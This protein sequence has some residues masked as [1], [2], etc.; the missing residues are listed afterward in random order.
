MSSSANGNL[1]MSNAAKERAPRNRTLTLTDREKAAYSRGLLTLSQSVS[2]DFV[3]NRVVRQDALVALAYLPDEC[4][5]LIIVDP[6]YNKNKRFNADCFS[7]TSADEYAAWVDSWLSLLSKKMTSTSSIYICSDWQSSTAIQNA[8]SRYFKIQNRITWEREKGRGAKR[9]W[10]NCAEDIWFCTKS[11][12]FTFNIDAVKLSRRVIAP[13]RE[14]DGAPRDWDETDNGNFRLTHPSNL[15]TDISVPFWS[16]PENTDHP[17]Q[18]PEKLIAKLIL[19]SSQP[20]DIVLDPFAGS[21]TT[22][23]VAKKTNRRFIA[24]EIDELYCCL[25]QKRLDLANT[26]STI[27]GYADGVFWE[28]NT[29]AIQKQTMKRQGQEEDDQSTLFLAPSPRDRG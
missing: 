29:L 5:N 13:Y 6:P 26:D 8:A 2:L 7:K 17:T 25:A 23:V 11:D 19:A 10:K 4:A 14:R 28:R 24:I 21:G 3:C 16:M 9:N 12:K 20:G 15:W 1:V 22:A 18:K 27:Q